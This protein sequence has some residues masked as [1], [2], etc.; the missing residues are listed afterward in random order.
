MGFL[1]VLLLDQLLGCW[2]FNHLHKIAQGEELLH[3]KFVGL[4]DVLHWLTQKLR[5]A[6]ITMA[7]SNMLTRQNFLQSQPAL[8]L[9]WRFAEEAEYCS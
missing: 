6:E 9:F 7:Q 4:V 8:P 3:C 5:S 2:I 1:E